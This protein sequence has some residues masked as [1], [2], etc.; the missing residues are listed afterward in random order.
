MRRFS[1]FGGTTLA[2]IVIGI[3]L[4]HTIS[5]Y[6]PLKD[7]DAFV[8]VVSTLAIIVGLFTF[9]GATAAIIRAITVQ[10]TMQLRSVH[11]ECVASR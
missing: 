1:F 4:G 9:L 8:F 11:N 7:V 10:N 2:S 5:G 6:F 3:V